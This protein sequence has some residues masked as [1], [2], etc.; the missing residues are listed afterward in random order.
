MKRGDT[1]WS[2]VHGC[3]VRLVRELSSEWE[4]AIRY[5]GQPER[6][7]YY[8]LTSHLAP[9]RT[10]A[11]AIA[12]RLAR[13]EEAATALSDAADAVAKAREAV[14]EA[15]RAFVRRGHG[16]LAES[17]VVLEELER[18]EAEARA[19]LEALR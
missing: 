16:P 3:E 15:A 6:A 2:A 8:V 4:V 5:H 18:A 19:R 17:V 13:R 11:A 14:V 7:G 12:Q 10:E 1:V 9:T